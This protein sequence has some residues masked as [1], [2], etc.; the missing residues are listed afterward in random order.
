[1]KW[2][3]LIS[4][5][6]V[7]GLVLLAVAAT[8]YRNPDADRLRATLIADPLL[9]PP[10]LVPA[11]GDSRAVVFLFS[12]LDGWDSN[13]AT[14]AEQLSGAG[15]TVVGIDV[16]AALPLLSKAA[17]D[18][19]DPQWR[20]QHLSHEIQRALSLPRYRLP[21]LAGVGA[22]GDLAAR[23]AESATPAVLGGAIVVDPVPAL[24]RPICNTG[25]DHLGAPVT[26]LPTGTGDGQGGLF[27]ALSERADAPSGTEAE[28]ADLPVTELPA[29]ADRNTL[30][31]VYSGDGGWRDLDKSIAEYLA[32]HGVPTVGLDMLRYYWTWKSPADSAADLSRLIRHYRA[33]WGI[34]RVVLVGYSFG[35]DV[36]PALYNL[37]PPEDRTHVAQISLLALSASAD[38]E[39]TVGS[40]LS[41]KTDRAQ[42]V[43][44]DLERIDPAMLQCFQGRDDGDAICDSLGGRG[45]SVVT[46]PGGHHFDGDYDALAQHILDRLAQRLATAPAVE[47]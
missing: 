5:G 35:A 46:T 9:G 26:R 3:L 33:A 41:A 34:D 6:L 37:L 17:G 10:H 44:P 15:I 31:I 20:V 25:D 22:G 29:A 28:L 14:L 23:I 27:R 18:C 1:M 43:R 42:P 11:Q 32:A 12:G 24:G 7:L 8:L 21:I 47:R 40:F 19:V 4:G 13:A 16:K 38:F 45:V 30:A 2:R 39:V 36:M